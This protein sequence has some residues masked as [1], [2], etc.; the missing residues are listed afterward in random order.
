M[1]CGV[2]SRGAKND[3]IIVQSVDGA[4]IVIDDEF[5]LFKVQLPDF[6]IPGPLAFSENSGCVIIS[7][8]KLEIESYNFNSLKVNTNNNIEEQ[9][10]RQE[11]DEKLKIETEWVCNIGEQARQIRMHFNKY[12]QLFDVV[13]LG[14]NSLFILNDH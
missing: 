4:L 12:T 11:R 1:I 14:E 5:I 3:Q 2:F 8:S 13:V 9:K 7:N 10:E 6:F